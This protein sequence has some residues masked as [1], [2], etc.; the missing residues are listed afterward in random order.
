MTVLAI[1]NWRNNAELLKDVAALGY[2]NGRVLDATYGRGRFW[3]TW[4]PTDM[5]SVDLATAA[6]VRADFRALPFADKTFDAVV[7]DPPYRMSGRRLNDEF[8]SRYGLAV[9][10]TSRECLDLL[11]EGAAECLRVAKSYLLIKCQDQVS[12]GRVVWQTDLITA[13]LVALGAQKVDRFEFMS[14]NRNGMNTYARQLH[15]RRN[16]STLLVFKRSRACEG[17]TLPE[18]RTSDRQGTRVR[19]PTGPQLPGAA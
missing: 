16:H 7:Y 13:T 19:F 10:L 3:T 18:D 2:L 8:H 11:T 5:V 14:R 4:Q 12:S 6:D 9:P 17:S 15:A 1:G